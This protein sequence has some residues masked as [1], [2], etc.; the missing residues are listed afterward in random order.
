MF[1]IN[2]GTKLPDGAK[3][4]F[5]CGAKLG[6][7]SPETPADNT[8]NTKLVPAKCT[9][10]GGQLTVDSNQ[11]SAV[12]PF[13]ETTFIVD[14]AINNY[15]VSMQGNMNIGSATINVNGLN[16]ENLVARAKS[17]ENQN[18]FEMALDYFN[19]VL[20]ID[21]NNLEAV[22]GAYRVQQKMKNFV[23]IRHA[24]KPPFSSEVTWEFTKDKI[25]VIKKNGQ[26][27][28][29]FLIK[30]I[31]NEKIV[32]ILVASSLQF[33]YPG[34]WTEVNIPFGT[35]V[36]KCKEVF[37]FLQNAKNGIYPDYK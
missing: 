12:C 1:C 10:C 31:K 36:D 17:Y 3:F 23:Y 34:K 6:E 30:Q 24:F 35:D 32:S 25:R 16:T 37:N 9:N 8:Q 20:D 14:Q 13:C 7:L 5:N 28:E 18:N 22:H 11:T 26:E 2:C 4:C 27:T 19:R 15:N 33:K 21:V 29:E